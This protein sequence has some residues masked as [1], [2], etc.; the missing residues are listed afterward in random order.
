MSGEDDGES[1]V[2][3]YIGDIA[4]GESVMGYTVGDDDD[5]ILTGADVGESVGYVVVVG[6]DDT[7]TGTDVGELVVGSTITD[8]RAIGVDV[9]DLVGGL[10]GDLVGGVGVDVGDE[11]GHPV[12]LLHVWF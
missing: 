9:G 2:V 6:D 10:V 1:V 4:V 5:D 11:V 7:I 3:V 8:G 12:V